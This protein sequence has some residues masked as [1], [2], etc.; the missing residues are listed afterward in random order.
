MAH[1]ILDCSEHNGSIDTGTLRRAGVEGCWT[2]CADGDHLDSFYNHARLHALHK[3]FGSHYGP[4]YYA[5]VASP[6]NGQRDGKKEAR[7]AVRIAQAGG[8]KFTGTFPLAYDFEEFNG[9]SAQKAARHLIQFIR[10]YRKLTG[11]YP[12]IYTMPGLWAAVL[13]HLSTSDLKLLE[14]C[15]LWEAHWDVS[16]A[17]P[18]RPWGSP[19]DVHQFTDHYRVAGIG[20]QVDMSRAHVPLKRLVVPKKAKPASDT[21]APKP[22]KEK[23][24]REKQW[25]KTV[26][27]RRRRVKKL[28]PQVEAARRT[29]IE[30]RGTDAAQAAADAFHELDAVYQ[31]SKAGV[32]SAEKALAKV[33]L[34]MHPSGVPSWVPSKYVDYWRRPWGMKAR[35]S[36]RFRAL[37][38]SHGYLAP[39]F[40]LSEAR[41]KDGTPVPGSMR[42]AC[43][44][45]AFNLERMRHEL[46]D[47]PIPVLSWYRTP[48]YNKKVGGAAGS[49]HKEAIATDFTKQWV[50][51]MGRTRVQRVAS[52]VF[53]NGGIGTYP[54]GNMHFDS[55][56]WPARWTSFTPG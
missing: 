28:R 48:A 51:A 52:V 7:M 11:H 44:A 2:R 53:R 55:R 43:Q 5:R 16:R 10:E 19:P 42:K 12:A 27:R 36:A 41:C 45:H 50:D 1:L 34:T 18:L 32:V 33:R 46:G 29:A 13:P 35:N 49:K 4:Y 47:R 15:R 22:P 56:G 30:A 20:G 31:A 23:L 25:V 38:L 3:A 8:W 21:P 40:P 26:Q 54:G 17:A 6:G 37:L 39:H 9:Q 24:S 14:R